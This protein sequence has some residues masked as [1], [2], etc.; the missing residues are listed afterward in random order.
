MRHNFSISALCIVLCTIVGGPGSSRQGVEPSRP[1][2]P[3]STERNESVRAAT[4]YAQSRPVPDYALDVAPLFEKYC[5][6]CHDASGA[7]G[8]VILENISTRSR[9]KR[10]PLLEERG[11]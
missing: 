1:V 2:P 11:R 6:S 5:L 9:E 3:V 7:E 8:G 4:Q 10:A